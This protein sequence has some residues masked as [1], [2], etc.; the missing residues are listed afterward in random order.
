MNSNFI[1]SI[2]LCFYL[3]SAFNSLSALSNKTDS[4]FCELQESYALQEKYIRWNLY[5]ETINCYER[6]PHLCI[7]VFLRAI[8][9]K[10]NNPDS[11]LVFTELS[12]LSKLQN[13]DSIA[14]NSPFS[15]KMREAY[16]FIPYPPYKG[17]DFTKLLL[18]ENLLIKVG[19]EM[20][21]TRFKVK[22]NAAI[23]SNDKQFILKQAITYVFFF[24]YKA[25]GTNREQNLQIQ[26][27]KKEFQQNVDQLVEDD[28]TLFLKSNYYFYWKMEEIDIPAPKKVSFE[29]ATLSPQSIFNYWE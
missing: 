9:P 12:E 22:L 10:W 27:F 1:K 5:E 4:I 29:D 3:L 8:Q 13:C 7:Q 26:K 17:V 23:M 25:R 2:V 19:C 15:Y 16:P 20:E 18:N 11:T 24:A 28:G 6:L 21:G 14:Q